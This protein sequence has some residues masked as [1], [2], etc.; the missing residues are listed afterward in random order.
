MHILRDRNEVQKMQSLYIL[1]EQN[2]RSLSQKFFYKQ[3]VNGCI[4][5]YMHVVM[6]YSLA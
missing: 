1:A 3:D 4:C 5:S 6:A 2:F